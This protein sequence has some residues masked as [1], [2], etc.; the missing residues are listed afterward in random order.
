M[1]KGTTKKG[2]AKPAR[3]SAGK[4]AGGAKASTA[5]PSKVRTAARKA[6]DAAV[7]MVE[8]PIVS[9]VVAAALMAAAASLASPAK[10]RKAAGLA[11]DGAAQAGTEAL[12]LGDALRRIAIDVARRTLD[13]WEETEAS[14]SGGRK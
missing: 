1:A 6:G 12:K 3:K 8:M 9:E 7:K 14:R 2:A 4:T 13:S 10:T 11:A 5:G